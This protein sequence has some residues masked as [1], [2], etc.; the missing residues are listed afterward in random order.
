[1]IRVV[2][3]RFDTAFKKAFSQPEIFCAF[4]NDVLDVR[5]RSDR[6]RQ[7]YKFI[8]PVAQV[9]IEYDLFAEDS[10]SRIVVEIQHVKEGHFFNR[11]LYY[12][13]A[14]LVD[15]VKSGDAYEIGQNAYTIVVLTSPFSG[16][17]LDFS[18]GISDFNPV[19]EFK[20]KV[21]AYPHQLVFLVPRMVNSETPPRVKAWLE[22]ILDSLEGEIDETRYDSPIIKKV[23]EAIR[24]EN[25]SASE[26]RVLKDEQEWDLTLKGQREKGREEG[27]EE[28]AE[29]A[30]ARIA[31]A[32]VSQGLDT[33]YIAE[34]TG[35]TEADIEKLRRN[36]VFS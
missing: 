1:M 22:L 34:T 32:L 2:P 16:D 25:I 33:A 17:Q 12:H 13:L 18:V 6:V 9:D 28:G 29:Q 10:A 23:I 11:F 35:M 3:L 4:A 7:G 30:T 15:Q 19:N 21:E 14:N 5:F 8:K 24:Y 20:R 31:R 26:L 36:R 27:L